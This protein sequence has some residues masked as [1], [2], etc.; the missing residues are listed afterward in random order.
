M[1]KFVRWLRAIKQRHG[2]NMSIYRIF[3]LI[4]AILGVIV[5]FPLVLF[6]WLVCYFSTRKPV[7][8][9]ERV[10]RN[11]KKFTLFKFRT[12][13]VNT[14]HVATHL[15]SSAQVTKVGRILRKTKLDELPQLINVLNGTMSFVGPRPCLPNQVE[16]IQLRQTHQV[17]KVRPG[18]TGLA[19]ILGIDMSEPEKLV[20]KEVFMIRSF[21][22]FAYFKYLLAT[23]FGRG[24]GDKIKQ[25]E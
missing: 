19:Q 15:A 5:L 17:F 18:I 20:A 10:G 3:D 21:N 13:H 8:A 12:M 7:F 22:V 6:I 1:K 2:D 16:L 14:P 24:Q 9:Q 4:I 23:F 11:Q 25:V